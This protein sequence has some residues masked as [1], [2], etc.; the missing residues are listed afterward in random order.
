MLSMYATSFFSDFSAAFAETLQRPPHYEH[1]QIQHP[2]RLDPHQTLNLKKSCNAFR[3]SQSTES[4]QKG[5]FG[6]VPL[7]SLHTRALLWPSGS[8]LFEVLP[9]PLK[10]LSIIDSM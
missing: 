2:P 8:S 5:S 3:D 4:P 10:C 9:G 1:P 6:S 7:G